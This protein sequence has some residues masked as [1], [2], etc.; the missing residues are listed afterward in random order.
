[1]ILTERNKAALKVLGEQLQ[2]GKKKL[3]VFY[4]AGHMSGL[5]KTLIDEMGFTRVGE[6]WLVAWDM[7]TPP[8]PPEVDVAKPAK[9]PVPAQPGEEQE[10]Q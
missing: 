1:M 5:E 6:K 10:K 8:A 4:G 3:G 2:K 7:T 9:A